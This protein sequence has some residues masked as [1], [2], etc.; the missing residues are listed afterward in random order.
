VVV[1]ERNPR[2]CHRARLRARLLSPPQLSD[3]VVRCHVRR[4]VNA[5]F[6][7]DACQVGRGKHR[8]AALIRGGNDLQR[9]RRER[10]VHAT[11]PGGRCHARLEFSEKLVHCGTRYRVPT[12]VTKRRAASA[13]RDQVTA[14]VRQVADG[15][16]PNRT[17]APRQP[18]DAVPGAS[19]PKPR[20]LLPTRLRVQEGRHLAAALE[21]LSTAY[22]FR[23]PTGRGISS[24]RDGQ[25]RSRWARRSSYAG[26]TA[27]LNPPARVVP[28]P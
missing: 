17:N 4:H 23:P 14:T 2:T 28:L 24:T 12:R 5:I 22:A 13:H 27:Q 7:R 21:A 18:T 6:L 1:D 10:R 15:E 25:A 19:H 3:D 9:F 11:R 26:L 20:N 16:T 8:R